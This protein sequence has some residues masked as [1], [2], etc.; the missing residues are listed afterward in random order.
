VLLLAYQS[1]EVVVIETCDGPIEICFSCGDEAGL[2]I[3]I[4]APSSMRILRRDSERK[5]CLPPH[6][7][8]SGDEPATP[9][10]AVAAPAPRQPESV[11]LFATPDDDDWWRH[12][13]DA[14]TAVNAATGPTDPVP[15]D[16]D[17]GWA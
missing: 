15:G 4:D 16:D 5:W 8:Q 6:H 10:A 9:V 12:P 17:P 13:D 7:G 3:G 11:P 2:R 1:R 14:K